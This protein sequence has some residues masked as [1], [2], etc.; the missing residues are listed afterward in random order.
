LRS[1][2]FGAFEVRTMSRSDGGLYANVDAGVEVT[3]DMVEAGLDVLRSGYEPADERRFV[4]AI[5]RSMAGAAER[6]GPTRDQAYRESAI[7]LLQAG[8]EAICIFDEFKN[9]VE[10]ARARLFDDP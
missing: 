3:L 4:T 9:K 8:A 1:K 2:D 6:M 10:A 5:Y 7:A